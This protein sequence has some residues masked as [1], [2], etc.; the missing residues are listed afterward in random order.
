MVAGL[1]PIWWLCLGLGRLDLHNPAA[2]LRHFSR[3]HPLA[4]GAMLLAIL[5]ENLI[6]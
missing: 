4:G 6:R 1:L 5:L 3:Q 2:C